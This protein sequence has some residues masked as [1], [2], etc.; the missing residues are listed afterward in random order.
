MK[1][2][3][4]I[5]AA[6]LLTVP[7]IAGAQ[8]ERSYH[9]KSIDATYTVHRDTS[10]DVEER[11]EFEFVGQYNLGYRDISHKGVDAV[12]DV[13]VIDAQS[14]EPL[15]YSRKKLDKTKPES[16]GKYTVDKDNG[17]TIVE[18][19]YNQKDTTHAWILRYKIH[20]AIAFYDTHDELYWNVFTDFDVPVDFVGA[21][22][23]LPEAITKRS[24]TLYTT[25]QH[26][27]N[28]MNSDEQSY[29]LTVAGIEPQEDVTFAVGWQKGVTLQSEYQKWFLK[30]IWPLLAGIAALVGSIAFSILYWRRQ[31][32]VHRGKG[33]VIP[34]YEPPHHL[35]PAMAEVAA[36]G[37]VSHRAWSATVVDFA[38]RGYVTIDEHESDGVLGWFKSK[39]FVVTRTGKSDSDLKEYEQKFMDA[40]FPAGE[41]VFSTKALSKSTTKQTAMVSNISKITDHLYKETEV[42]TDA[43]TQDPKSLL[44]RKKIGGLI[45][46]AP[47]V[48]VASFLVTDSVFWFL[49]LLLSVAGV[50]LV[51]YVVNIRPQLNRTGHIL[52]EEWQGFKLFLSV[53]GRDRMQNLTPDMFEKFLPYAMMFGVEKKWALA[54]KDITLT[55]PTWYHS[56]AAVYAATIP[57]GS[58]GSFSPT[59]FASG[60]SASFTSSFASSGGS[61]ASG[62]GGGAGGGGG[63]GGGGAS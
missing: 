19:Y 50:A 56:N 40:L 6:A 17:S 48:A 29:Y 18:W 36:K 35:P 58:S 28:S 45:F 49:G 62:G 63:G 22:I 59:S 15:E 3:T 60:F 54:F 41:K 46:A 26:E 31:E 4:K 13:Q 21:T 5:L 20:G 11:Q 30:R 52:R 7:L 37:S 9:Y 38:V 61:G 51:V 16:W 25:N 42:H 10:V 8:A 32:Y 34:Q 33:T 43:Y 55:P 39:D 1:L 44:L 53:T 27:Y 14:G 12:T 57:G 2:L 47:I 23:T 24:G